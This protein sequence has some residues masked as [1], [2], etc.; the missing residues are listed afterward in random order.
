[1]KLL[2]ADDNRSAR[3]ILRTTLERWGYEVVEA[4]NG[5]EA[6][7]HLSAA[8]P[9]RIAVLDWVMP[10]LDGTDVCRLLTGRVGGPLVYTLLLTS[11]TETEDIVLGL[12]S[13]AHDFLSKPVDN[14]ELKSRIAVGERLIQAE[15]S[16]RRAM[17]QIQTL[18]GLLP[19]CAHC[20]SVRDDAGYWQAIESYVGLH[21][22]AEFSHSI[23]PDCVT[24][25]YPNMRA[26]QTQEPTI[27][28]GDPPVTLV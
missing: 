23:C 17:E 26:S 22:A 20:K 15:D 7:E 3:L 11:K 19:I 28:H 27:P 1:M 5:R 13:G 9:P 8:N 2:I 16:L 18:R 25:L 12:D 24:K 21:S 14:R 10:Q 4:A 6:W